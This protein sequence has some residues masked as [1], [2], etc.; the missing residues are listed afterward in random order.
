MRFG[1]SSKSA[2]LAISMLSITM[3]CFGLAG[4]YYEIPEGLMLLFFVFIFIVYDYSFIHIW[5][6]SRWFRK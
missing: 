6:I 1:F 4:E 3:A 2:L 5:K